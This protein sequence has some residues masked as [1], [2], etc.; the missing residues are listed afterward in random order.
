M[1]EEA[2]G[3]RPRESLESHIWNTLTLC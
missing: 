3:M 2:V 1:E